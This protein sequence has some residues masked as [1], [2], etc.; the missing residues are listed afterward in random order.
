MSGINAK[1]FIDE[2]VFCLN[3]EDV[4]KAKAL[5]QF[6]S[7][8]DVDADV[9]RKALIELAKGPEKIVFPLLEYLIKVD[10]S[11]PKIQE[12]LYELILDK[13]FG[14]IDLVIKYITQNEKK[15]RLLFLKA[16]GDLIL[17]DTA[18][19]LQEII[20]QEKD[21]DILVA[22]ISS[23]GNLRLSESL[24]LFA[25]MA[26]QPDK[27]IQQAAIFAIA[28]MGSNDAVDKLL[29]FIGE[30]EQINKFAVDALAEIQDLY[31]LDKLTT[32]LSS[33]IT[34][35]RDTAI[36]QLMKLGN[37]ATPILTKAFQN[38]EADYLVHLVTT[39]GYI[40]DPAA[41]TPILDIVNTQPEDANIRQAAYEAMERIPSPK[42]AISLVQGLQDPV[43]AVRMSA[44]RAIDKNLS[45][46]LVAGLRN[47]V[48]EGSADSKNAVAALI[49]S[50]ASNIF[51][52]LVEEE[53]FLELAGTYVATKADPNTRNAF[54]KQ[55]SGIGQKEFAESIAQK[56]TE[57]GEPENKEAQIFVVD[58][59]KMMLKLYQNKLTALGFKP[60]TFDRPEDAIPQI[61]QK[62]PNL[63]ITDL[64]M[65]NISGL[66]LT[67]EIRK[68][69]SRQDLPILMITTQSDFVEEKE[70]DIKVNDT[71]LTKSGINMILHKPFTDDE[72]HKAIDSFITP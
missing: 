43:E 28:E 20:T 16:A 50:D 29:G 44:A 59:S 19:T 72:F 34:I 25:D 24:P 42:T 67:R 56:V 21:A 15:A 55:M 62:K 61:I 8:A 10:I 45:K 68:K 18:P 60:I 17:T 65:P 49:D 14:N 12:S 46:A 36:D 66:E 53:S 27:A 3:E 71:V 69:Y 63:V 40:G 64:N 47:V 57:N 70:G 6:A 37:K 51:N 54:L 4:V 5:L 52:F 23:L 2:L 26:N 32:L 41:I 11:N 39:L 9:Q 31:A 58:D 13:A 35:V 38:A 7:D 22:A 48:R 1:E 30:D 33:S